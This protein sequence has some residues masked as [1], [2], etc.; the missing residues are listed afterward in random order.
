VTCLWFEH[1]L[2]ERMPWRQVLRPDTEVE[3]GG[4]LHA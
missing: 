1:F 2:V 3:V 4:G